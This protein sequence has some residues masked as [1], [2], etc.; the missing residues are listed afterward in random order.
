MAVYV[1]AW[2]LQA[3][4]FLNWDVSWLMLATRRLLEGGTYSGN[5]F[6]TNPPL[7]LFL[8]MPPVILGKVTGISLALL[9]R[10]YIFFLASLSLGLCL[11]LIQRLFPR[12]DAGLAGY[13]LVTLAIIYL[14]VPMYEFGQRDHLLV[15]LSLPYF[16]LVSLRLKNEAFNP[17]SAILIGVLA[18]IGFSI[19]PHFFM[20]PILVELYYLWN[21]KTWLAWVRIETLTIAAIVLVYLAAILRFFPDYVFFIVPFSMRL[22]YFVLGDPWTMLVRYPLACFCLLPFL[23]YFI[24]DK[25]KPYKGLSIVLLLALSG[26]LF[27]YFSQRITLYYHLLPSFSL[28]ILLQVLFFGLFVSKPQLG[29]R[30]YF[31]LSL[32]GLFV[33]AG[34]FFWFSSIWTLLIFSPRIFFCFFGI[35]FVVILAAAQP[36][37][38]PGKIFG[39]VLLIIFLSYLGSYLA[40]RTSLYPHAFLIT[41]FLLAAPFVL[42]SANGNKKAE[43]GRTVRSLPLQLFTAVL[44]TLIF[45]LPVCFL[46]ERYGCAEYYKKNMVIDLTALSKGQ[47]THPSVYF[48]HTAMGSTFMSIEAGGLELGSRFPFMWPVAGLVNRESSPKAALHRQQLSQDKEVILGMI[49]DDFN[50][51]KPD[52]VLVDVSEHKAHIKDKNF[53][54]LK[55]FSTNEAFRKVWKNYRYLTT[56]E[57]KQFYKMAVYKREKLK[58][59]PADKSM[60]E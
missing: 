22:Y 8:Y 36:D 60:G 43:P 47:L 48:F 59:I 26:F 55:Y 1:S 49:I 58:S 44:A 4:F 7:I 23:F 53:D 50:K 16:L 13:V 39:S 21:K 33:L 5:F 3:Q 25:G 42:I 20:A 54:Y 41:L 35:L 10:A 2:F 31:R 37:K 45:A 57:Q 11:W 6:E 32:L 40:Q 30:S 46:N 19:K 12:Q 38:N 18:G 17:C 34:I 29:L 51:N 28:A 24:M 9:L 14:I 56:V 27:S 15:I 52:L